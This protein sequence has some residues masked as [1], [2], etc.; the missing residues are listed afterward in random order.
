MLHFPTLFH[1]IVRW[2]TLIPIHP[3]SAFTVWVSDS[4]VASVPLTLNTHIMASNRTGEGEGGP[5]ALFAQMYP[6]E[7]V[8][9]RLHVLYSPAHIITKLIFFLS[10]HAL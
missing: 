7:F 9:F 3:N 10:A 1:L 8:A 4:L 2:P 5:F 6:T